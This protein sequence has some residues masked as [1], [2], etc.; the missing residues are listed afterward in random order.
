MGAADRDRLHEINLRPETFSTT[1][2][3]LATAMN[4]AITRCLTRGCSTGLTVVHRVGRDLIG[5]HEDDEGGEHD[6]HDHAQHPRHE[7]AEQG[8]STRR[9]P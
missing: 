2:A 1:P 3:A 5:D 4:S 7:I 9:R 6:H 8:R